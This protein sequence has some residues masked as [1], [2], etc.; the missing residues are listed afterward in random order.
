MGGIG[1]FYPFTSREDA[2]FFTHL[3]MHLRQEHPPLCGRWALRTLPS[4]PFRVLFALPQ[5]PLCLTHAQSLSH[6]SASRV[7]CIVAV[8]PTAWKGCA[9]ACALVSLQIPAG[10]NA[11]ML[12]LLLPLPPVWM[13]PPARLCLVPPQGPC[14]RATMLTGLASKHCTARLTPLMLLRPPAAAVSDH[15]LLLTPLL[16][17]LLLPLPSPF[18]PRD[19][20]AYRSAYWPVKDCV[21]GDLCA[22][23]PSVSACAFPPSRPKSQV[24][25][26]ALSTEPH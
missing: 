23:Y 2:D 17:L 19:H 13:L 11:V 1:A 14:T 21:D 12:V 6:S 3:E 8:P 7:R 16:L 9:A 20:M 18:E 26:V 10:T 4:T 5:P 25:T 24:G 15:H 22:Q